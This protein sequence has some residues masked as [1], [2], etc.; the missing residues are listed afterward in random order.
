MVA[1]VVCAVVAKAGL[2]SMGMPLGTVAV[3]LFVVAGLLVVGAL[4]RFVVLPIM[5]RS[6]PVKRRRVILVD[7]P[8][9]DTSMAGDGEAFEEE[10]VAELAAGNV[11][12]LPGRRCEECGKSMDGKRKDARYCSAPC[13][14]KGH[15]KRQA[16]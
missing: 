11:L 6:H 14:K 4:L 15:L 9:R 3:G 5:S 16:L 7:V 2:P 10:E 12:A 1:I 8:A 13:R